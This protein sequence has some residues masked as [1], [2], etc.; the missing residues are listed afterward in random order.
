[1]GAM[2]GAMGGSMGGLGG[3]FGLDGGVPNGGGYA[4]STGQGAYAPGLASP[5]AYGVGDPV[6][7]PLVPAVAPNTEYHVPQIGSEQLYKNKQLTS[8]FSNKAGM[9]AIGEMIGRSVAE[10]IGADGRA[11]LVAK[12]QA[13]GLTP[14]SYFMDPV[15]TPG[16]PYVPSNYT[17][18]MYIP[19]FSAP[20]I[21]NSVPPLNPSPPTPTTPTPTTTTPTVP[22]ITTP[23][24]SINNLTPNTNNWS[25]GGRTG[26]NGQTGFGAG[27]MGAE[28]GGIGSAIRGI[29]A[30][31]S[32]F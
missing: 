19:P 13:K 18:A 12:W 3:S 1:M 4:T 31:R 21:P 29:V 17:N 30:N 5:E 16:N 26:S 2:G 8:G 28:G 24:T 25:I 6:Y 23:T 11:N 32:G 22:V 7:H 9:Q 15:Y 27:M 20:G 14:P 10:A